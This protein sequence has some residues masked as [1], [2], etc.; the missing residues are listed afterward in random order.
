[1]IEFTTTTLIEHLQKIENK[2]GTL[3][4]L[5]RFNLNA[6]KYGHLYPGNVYFVDLIVN[7]DM[8]VVIDISA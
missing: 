2:Y 1:M 5:Y 7:D 6:P 8:Q 4:I 3:P